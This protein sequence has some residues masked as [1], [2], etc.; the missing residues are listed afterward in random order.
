MVSLLRT[1]IVIRVGKKEPGHVPDS[2]QGC[3]QLSAV[4]LLAETT[5][6]GAGAPRQAVRGT[7]VARPGLS[8]RGHMLAW[9]DQEGCSWRNRHRM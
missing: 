4:S 8:S 1:S 3:L 6:L 7:D 5:H 2:Q 9:Q